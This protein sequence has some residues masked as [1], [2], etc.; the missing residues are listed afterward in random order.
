DVYFDDRLAEVLISSVRLGDDQKRSPEFWNHHRF[1][2]NLHISSLALF[3][4]DNQI[5][6][7]F[8]VRSF[9]PFSMNAE[10]KLGLAWKAQETV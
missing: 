7:N 5:L 6:R 2:T 1:A 8:E 3:Q 10:R 9:S 4:Y